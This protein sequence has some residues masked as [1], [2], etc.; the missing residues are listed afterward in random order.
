ML[1]GEQIRGA[2]AMAR[3]EQR[4]LAE[5]AGVSIETAKRLE[6]KV[7]TLSALTGTIAAIRTAL[8]S[9]GV[10]FV[11]ENGHGPG[12]RLRKGR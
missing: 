3:M 2:R 1:T 12:V 10:I 7:G 8:E 4:E 6:S 9:A 5:K 11:D